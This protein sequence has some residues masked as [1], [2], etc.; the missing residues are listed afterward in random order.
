MGSSTNIVDSF[1]EQ[2]I[3]RL[4]DRFRADIEKGR[5]EE[6][7]AAANEGGEGPPRKLIQREE[8]AAAQKTVGTAPFHDV[9][10]AL[11][12]KDFEA[13][14]MDDRRAVFQPPLAQ[15]SRGM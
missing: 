3:T 12:S 4:P 14:D 15:E 5:A 2:I 1:K 11:P 13:F 8:G 10:A 6:R 9:P 7:R